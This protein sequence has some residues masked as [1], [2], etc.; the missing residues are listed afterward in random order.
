M[1]SPHFA[2]WPSSSDRRHPERSQPSRT[3]EDFCPPVNGH[4]LQAPNNWIPHLLSVTGEV[5][6]PLEKKKRMA[7]A[8]L[9]VPLSSQRE[10]KERPSVIHCSQ[11]PARAS[12]GR[13]CNS[14]EGSPLPL[15]S[16]SSRSSSPLSVSSEESPA[17]SGDKPRPSSTSAENCSMAAKLQEDNKPVSCGQT[18][19]STSA[20]KKDTPLVSS[21]MLTTDSVKS[22]RKDSA[23]NLYHKVPSKYFVNPFHSSPSFSHPTSSFTKVTPKS[24]QLVRPSPVR[25]GY[26]V[27]HSRL[28]QTDNSLPFTKK[29]GGVTP[30]YSTEK[31]DRSRMMQ[32]KV[33]PSQQGLAQS[34]TPLPA[35]CVLSNYD[36]SARDSRQPQPLHPALLPHRM[37][38]PHSQLMYHSMPVGPSHSALIG[39]AVYPFPYS[40][41]LLS[42]QV[43]YPL[44][45]MSSVY[46]HKLWGGQLNMLE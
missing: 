29:L 20:Q 1:M 24:V 33:P 18:P 37:R 13:N 17:G 15:S 30:W 23:C 34:A 43:G 4:I 45:A 39:P 12:S 10:D 27:L 14:S 41:P 25:P 8:S 31:R 40:I 2:L 35:S 44:P 9:S 16:S 36:K 7:Q 19:T 42:P 3:A 38:F 22:Q 6:S 11:S 26:K 32:Q 5:I 46:P 21:Q 28:L